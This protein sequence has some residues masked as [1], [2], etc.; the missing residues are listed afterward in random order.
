M[1]IF[2]RSTKCEY[3]FFLQ[4]KNLQKNVVLTNVLIWKSSFYSILSV[5][6]FLFSNAVESLMLFRL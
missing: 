4:R 5:L 1:K 3:C 6:S 2:V